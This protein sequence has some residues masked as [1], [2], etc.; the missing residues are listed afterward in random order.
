MLSHFFVIYYI[1][2]ADVIAKL[3]VAV[4]LAKPYGRCD[5]HIVVDVVTTCNIV[6]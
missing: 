3:T 6:L 2:L 1:A 5:C 4:L